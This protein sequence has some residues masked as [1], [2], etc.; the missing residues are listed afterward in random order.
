MKESHF[1]A[2]EGTSLR[3]YNFIQLD[4]W[5][6]NPAFANYYYHSA[7]GHV[8][9]QCG[10]T[11]EIRVSTD[12]L[13]LNP[14]M[15]FKW[16]QDNQN[17]P[18]YYDEGIRFWITIDETPKEYGVPVQYLKSSNQNAFDQYLSILSMVDVTSTV[19]RNSSSGLGCLVTCSSGLAP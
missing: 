14:N 8:L 6:T 2:F 4:V 19:R 11:D 16:H 7:M 15:G 12:L 17:G 3:L 13:M 10:R 9:A 1:W 5:Q 18:I